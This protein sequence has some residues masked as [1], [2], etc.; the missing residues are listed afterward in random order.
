MPYLEIAIV[1]SDLTIEG[2]PVDF[3]SALGYDKEP[4]LMAL[5]IS[6][7]KFGKAS[8]PFFLSDQL[9]AW[10]YPSQSL[11]QPD[12]RDLDPHFHLAS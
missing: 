2:F 12:A 1:L 7:R 8:H 10:L 11:Y 5:P 6:G 3:G 4:V 9:A